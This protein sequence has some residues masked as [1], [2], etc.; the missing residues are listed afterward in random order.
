MTRS[1]LTP[2]QLSSSQLKAILSVIRIACD[3]L[4]ALE[5]ILVGLIKEAEK[6]K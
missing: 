4:R 6:K 1:T 3:M 2:A 5:P